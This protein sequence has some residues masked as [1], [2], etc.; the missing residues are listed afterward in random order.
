[1]KYMLLVYLN[2]QAQNETERKQCYEESARLTQELHLL[3]AG[4]LLPQLLPRA[5]RFPPSSTGAGSN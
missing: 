3:P 5:Q 2:E 1:M 4:Q